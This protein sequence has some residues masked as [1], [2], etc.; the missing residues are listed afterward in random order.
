MS[1]NRVNYPELLS[2]LLGRPIPQAKSLRLARYNQ[3]YS[4]ARQ[5]LLAISPPLSESEFQSEMLALEQKI[6]ALEE[7]YTHHSSTAKSEP[8]TSHNTTEKAETK[9]KSGDTESS[10]TQPRKY[11]Y[12]SFGLSFL[13]L[14]CAGGLIWQFWPRND[15]TSRNDVISLACI[16]DED[17]S[18]YYDAKGN[19]RE[20]WY[21]PAPKIT[22]FL[23]GTATDKTPLLRT[24]KALSIGFKNQGNWAEKLKGLDIH[25]DHDKDHGNGYNSSFSEKGPIFSWNLDNGKPWMRYEVDLTKNQVHHVSYSWTVSFKNTSS[26]ESHELYRCE[27]KVDYEN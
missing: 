26:I 11:S 9:V 18:I 22:V 17:F 6:N 21:S 24:S 23:V 13:L 19:I 14:C 27:R 8:S 10:S 4:I 20:Q 25:F 7:E 1:N 15:V 16:S 12:K 5:Q 2:H 3:A